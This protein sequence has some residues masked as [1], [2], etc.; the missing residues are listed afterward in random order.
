M[1]FNI[2]KEAVIKVSYDFE[3]EAESLEDAMEAIRELNL[4]AFWVDEDEF[5]SDNVE[6]LSSYGDWDCIEETTKQI[7][8]EEHN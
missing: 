8:D 5:E 6:L 1:I 3:I 2:K 7:T 4:L